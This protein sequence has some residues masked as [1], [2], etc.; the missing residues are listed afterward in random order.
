MIIILSIPSAACGIFRKVRASSEER[1]QTNLFLLSAFYLVLALWI[2]IAN[3]VLGGHGSGFQITSF[4]FC[5]S[6]VQVVGLAVCGFG[7]AARSYYFGF[8]LGNLIAMFAL[9]LSILSVLAPAVSV[10]ST[11]YLMM[12]VWSFVLLMLNAELK[13]D[14]IE[15]NSERNAIKF[16]QSVEQKFKMLANC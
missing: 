5:R 15:S 16:E 9:A 1:R 14:F 2:L 12:L 4:S 11:V 10:H 7:I 8:F 13:T 3:C 6:L